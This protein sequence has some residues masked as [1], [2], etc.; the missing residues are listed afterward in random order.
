M[1]QLPCTRCYQ[2]LISIAICTVLLACTKIEEPTENGIEKNP[3]SSTVITAVN[4]KEMPAEK[5]MIALVGATLI[6]G[7]GGEPLADACVLINGNII[8]EVGKNETVAIPQDAEIVDVTGLYLLPGLIDAHFHL[9]RVKKLPHHFLLHGITSLRDPGAWIEAYEDERASGYPLPRLFLTGPHLDM[10]PPAYP[11]DAFLVRDEEE[12][13]LQVNRMADQG[14][15][16]IKIYFRV[17]LGL[18]KAICTAAH[19]H[20]LPVTSHLEITHARDAILAGVDGI[21]HVTSFGIS[22]IPEREAEKYRQAVLADNNARRDGRYAIWNTININAKEVD[23]LLNFLAKQQTFLT[24]TL[25]AFEY[26]TKNGKEDSVKL[27]GFK[28]MMAFVGK[29]KKAGVPIVVGSHSIIPYADLGWAYHREMELLVES[30]M[31]NAEVIVAATM[32][33]A[34]FFKINDRL[35]SIEKGKQADLILVSQNPLDDISAMRKIRGVM[36]NGV[37]VTDSL[38]VQ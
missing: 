2:A 23:S 33:N 28:N 22:L 29:A 3:V 37:W 30:G 31:R 27:N 17:S 35:G 13:Q 5:K 24:P 20:G 26:R 7:N 12:A 38:P 15:S 11:H 9:D 25:G 34:R 19:Q 6:D 18:I 4:E 21:E 16:A 1:R 36:L 14:A 10:P 32:E 8:A